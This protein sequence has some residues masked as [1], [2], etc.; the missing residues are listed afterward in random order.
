MNVKWFLN[1]LP[2]VALGLCA[3]TL[4]MMLAMPN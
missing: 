3:L 1:V 2:L 4:V